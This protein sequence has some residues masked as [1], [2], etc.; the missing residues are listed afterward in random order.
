MFQKKNS[1]LEKSIFW[2][3]FFYWILSFDPYCG[4]IFSLKWHYLRS[5]NVTYD[6]CIPLLA[7]AAL[8]DK[9]SVMKMLNKIQAIEWM[10]II[11]V[12]LQQKNRQISSWC[13]FEQNKI[14]CFNILVDFQYSFVNVDKIE[15]FLFSMY[16]HQIDR[17]T[18]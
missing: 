3:T 16:F 14:T 11:T 6:Q 13:W 5:N 2:E 1:H 9:G 8:R 12:F 7:I 4:W 18:F 15:F 10:L 17:S